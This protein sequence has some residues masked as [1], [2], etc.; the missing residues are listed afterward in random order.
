MIKMVK[1]LGTMIIMILMVT[2]RWWGS[3]TGCSH[4]PPEG[5]CEIVRLWDCEIALQISFSL[6]GHEIDI[7]RPK[8]ATMEVIN[9]VAQ[10]R[11]GHCNLKLWHFGFCIPSYWPKLVP[12][13]PSML[14]WHLICNVYRLEEYFFR[15]LDQRKQFSPLSLHIKALAQV[16]IF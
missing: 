12:W 11:R 6:V 4:S 3:S 16:T 2:C 14:L 8:I 7:K 9:L 1:I 5:H 13:T 15:E 10:S